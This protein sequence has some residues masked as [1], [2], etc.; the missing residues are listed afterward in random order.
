MLLELAFGTLTGVGLLLFVGWLVWFVCS[1]LL[2]AKE[3]VVLGVGL[4][5]VREIHR[6]FT[7]ISRSS[8]GR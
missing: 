1:W 3:D 2:P 6:G 8:W 7:I 5:V 4:F